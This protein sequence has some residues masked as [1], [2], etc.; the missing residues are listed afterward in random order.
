MLRLFYNIFYVEQL[1]CIIDMGA[2]RV[3]FDTK[4]N[5]IGN[6]DWKNG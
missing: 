5:D 3:I 4:N 1:H 2:E 6:N